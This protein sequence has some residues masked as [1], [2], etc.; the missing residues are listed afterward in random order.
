MFEKYSD[1]CVVTGKLRESIS[2]STGDVFL[3]LPAKALLEEIESFSG[4]S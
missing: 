2:V 3:E 1:L 4:N